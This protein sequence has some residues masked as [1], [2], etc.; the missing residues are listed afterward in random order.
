ML[1]HVF[2]IIVLASLLRA[3]AFI[4]SST[5]LRMDVGVVGMLLKSFIV[6]VLLNLSD[7]SLS[8]VLMKKFKSLML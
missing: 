2:D 5:F 1:G 6:L 3:M 8:I 4:W 7:R